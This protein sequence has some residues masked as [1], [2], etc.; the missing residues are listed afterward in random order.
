MLQIKDSF[1][2]HIN[3]RLCEDAAS[4]R[5]RQFSSSGFGYMYGQI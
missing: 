2:V 3:F 5:R 1:I 4:C